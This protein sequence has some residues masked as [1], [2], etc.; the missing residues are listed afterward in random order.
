[1]CENGVTLVLPPP[2][3]F[4]PAAF[5]PGT[6]ARRPPSRPPPFLPPRPA[7]P[8][9]PAAGQHRR[10]QWVQAYPWCGCHP[11][12]GQDHGGHDGGMSFFDGV[13]VPTAEPVPPWSQRPWDPP[14][15][16]FPGVVPFRTL[17][18]ARTERAAV[19]ITGLS[20]YAAG[21]EIYVTARFRPG[22][23]TGPGGPVPG[24]PGP[25]GPGPGGPLQSFRFGLQLA[26][27]TTVIGRRGSRGLDGDGEPDGPILRMFLGGASPRS[28]LSRWWAWPLPPAGP[29]EFV[30]EWP[31]LGI[32][33]SRAGLDAQLILDAAG[34]STR[35]WPDDEG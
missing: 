32:P 18:L 1:M 30:C 29:L 26:D 33:E 6:P 20:A 22:T 25:G 2:A 34:Q 15:A 5:P 16:G 31:T 7:P 21:V 3:A 4:P 17:I 35:L 10:T 24:G 14:E 28:S 11:L 19:A 27:G 12:A 8:S 23:D 13:P 9:F